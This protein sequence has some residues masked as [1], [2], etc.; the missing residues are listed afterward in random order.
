[1]IIRYLDPWGKGIPKKRPLLRS[2]TGE[3]RPA[4]AGATASSS[5]GGSARPAAD[6]ER[7][8]RSPSQP[9]PYLRRWKPK[10]RI[11]IGRDGSGRIE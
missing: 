8:P 9:P 7:R 3:E 5:R 6:E 10:G 1:M 11:I 4:K 2:E